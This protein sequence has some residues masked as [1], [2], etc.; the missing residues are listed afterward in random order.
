MKMS[1][2]KKAL[3]EYYIQFGK[4]C[5]CESATWFTAI[6]SI[7]WLKIHAHATIKAATMF[8]I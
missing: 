7:I 5:R 8:N 4:I 3:S 2:K 1:K 6:C